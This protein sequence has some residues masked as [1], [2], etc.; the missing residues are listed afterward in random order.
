MIQLQHQESTRGRKRKTYLSNGGSLD[1]SKEGM[2]SKDEQNLEM[3]RES[4]LTVE[5]HKQ[6][7]VL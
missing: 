2:V 7:L 3:E 4:I 1:S 6:T 5:R